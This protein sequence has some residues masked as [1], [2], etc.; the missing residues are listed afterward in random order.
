MGQ[1]DGKVAI[2]T[3]AA[4]GMGESHARVFAREGARVVLTDLQEEAGLAV[5]KDIGD[6]ARYAAQDVSREED[7]DQV[8]ATALDA[9]GRV[10]VL[11]NNAAIWW[12]ARIE[13][14]DVDGLRRMLEVNLIGTWWGIRKVAKPMRDSGGGSIINVSSIAGSI[15]IPEYGS[16]AASKWAVRGLTKVAAQELGRYGIRVNSIHP[17]GISG[18]GMFVMNEEEQK[19]MFRMQPIRRAGEREEVSRLAVFLASDG[20]AYITG[21]EHLVDGGRNIW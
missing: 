14:E 17:G 18:T 8:I 11:I 20:S 3:G 19:E 5:A 9:F 1:L 12:T 2:I 4:Q 21:H 10:D 15:G 7:W 16:Y 13:D 6:A